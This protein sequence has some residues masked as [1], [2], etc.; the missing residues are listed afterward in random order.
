VPR[1]PSFL[2]QEIATIGRDITIP[3]YGGNRLYP[4]DETLL[5]RGGGGWMAYDIYT[6]LAKDTHAYAVLQKRYME[7]VGREW[8][9]KAASE[10]AIDVKA[11]DMVREQLHSL[12]TRTDR[13]E[14][15][16]Q[17][18]TTG[19]G[20]DSACWGLLNAILY[21]FYPAELMWGQDGKEIYLDEIRLKDLRRFGFVAA[22][23]GYKLR[24][25]TH[26]NPFDGM[27]VPPRKFLIHRFASL[28][29]EDP[30]GLGLGTRLF[31]PTYFKRNA[32][33]FWL[34]FAD[35]WATPTAVAKHPR[36]ATTEQ[37]D[38]YLAMLEAIA[39][40]AGIAIPEDVAIEFLEAQRSGTI[41]CYKGLVEFCNGEMSKCV[42]GETGGTDQS[43]SGGS[44]ARDEVGER[45]RLAMAKLDADLLS[46]TLNRTLIP[47]IVQLNLPDAKPPKIWRKF[48]ELESKFD[49]TGEA[50]IIV[51]L[52]NAGFK[53]T[54]EW[55]ADRFDIE[56][57]PEAP[58]APANN[59]DA[60]PDL[61]SLFGGGDAASA[62]PAENAPAQPSD[63]KPTE[64][65][66][67]TPELAE[68]DCE[69]LDFRM[70]TAQK[71]QRTCKKGYSCGYTCI[72]RGKQCR[73][74]LDKNAKAYASYLEAQI[75]QLQAQLAAKTAPPPQPGDVAQI[76]PSEILADPKRF[77]YK[78][79]G[80]HTTTGEVGSLSGVKKFDPN[81]AGVVQAWIDPAD[82]KTYVVN[83]H[84]RLALAKRLGAEQVTVRY[85]DVKDA[86][87]ARA[88]GAL[89]N[90]AEGR[91]D[92]M[93]AAKF[94]KDSGLSKEDLDRKGIPMR[95][96]VATDGIALSKLDD[97][98]FR[99]VIDG[100][101][102]TE[103]A[104]IVGGSGLDHQQQ[105][106]LVKLVDDQSKKRKITNEVLTELV[107]TVKASQQSTET[108]FDLF[109]ASST[110]VD[111]ALER[112]TLQAA[113]K[114][115][116]SREK[117]LFGTVGKS[118]AAQQ[119]AQA[120][121]VIDVASSQ[122]VSKD[123]STTLAVFDQLKNQSGGISKA[124][125]ETA[126][127]IRGGGDRKKA[128]ADLY[129]HVLQLVQS[130]NFSEEAE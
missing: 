78:I 90:I 92:A 14:D 18:I 23:R 62:Q 59:P 50:T 111:N 72:S 85:L 107:D 117:K 10:D 4:R 126:N 29:T 94:F 113:M 45:V 99:K 88:V 43:G 70:G 1:L 77:Q 21:G 55:V 101:I 115:R 109:G 120:G 27:P 121:N 130:G 58:A 8:E 42:L 44:R 41:D 54:R 61:G 32:V 51:S 53:P 17:I 67:D 122:K 46:E 102:P 60:A 93:D 128:E 114:K 82:G 127:H 65:T 66:A 19:G 28:P 37:R 80:E 124:I 38:R 30:H 69:T 35:K 68:P 31:Y 25:L 24:L 71:A 86:Q 112:A 87:E 40:D 119:L 129:K 100:D 6:D 47:W 96:K 16:E 64:D 116:L 74:Q 3:V 13:E 36:N 7:V 125:N 84:N 81:L 105:R 110:V 20:F 106:S 11:A 63:A 118:T 98:L 73:S 108:Q 12:A 49:R 89:T 9:V 2:S 91:G 56:L 103:R 75:Q 33:K 48:P 22:D 57:E 34:T 15:G 26:G 97:A 104:V 83:G 39:S 79:L 5:T 123:A 76:S 95:E 52:T